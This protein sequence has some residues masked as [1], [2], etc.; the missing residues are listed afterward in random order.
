MSVCVGAK[1]VVLQLPGRRACDCTSVY[2]YSCVFTVAH[3]G[4]DDES[5]VY[6]EAGEMVIALDSG[7][8]GA[9]SS[10]EL[11]ESGSKFVRACLPACVCL[12]MYE[13]SVSAS[14]R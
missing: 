12:C 10:F 1:R 13:K 5:A 14:N 2:V 6:F 3:V 7:P 8:L 11:M 4:L 9:E